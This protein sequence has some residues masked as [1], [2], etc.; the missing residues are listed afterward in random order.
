MIDISIPEDWILKAK[1]IISSRNRRAKQK[2]YR[3][4]PLQHANNYIGQVFQWAVVQHFD[5]YGA[6]EGSDPFEV[7]RFDV[8]IG[9]NEYECKCRGI[10]VSF[11][12]DWYDVVVNADQIDK[13]ADKIIFGFFKSKENVV[14]IAGK[15]SK[16][17][18]ISK[19][20]KHKAGDIMHPDG[21]HKEPC[22]H[23]W[24]TDCWT[25]P[26]SLLGGLDNV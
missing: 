6:K 18:F 2:G 10:N 21:H 1:S 24:I 22:T 19:A 9:E 15:I 5:V 25:I 23:K 14:V 4:E 12:P 16:E 11:I 13:L 7:D 17:D 26:I 8:V 3:S 20:K